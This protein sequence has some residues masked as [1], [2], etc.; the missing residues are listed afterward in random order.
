MLARSYSQVTSI[1]YFVFAKLSPWSL[2]EQIVS[3]LKSRQGRGNLPILDTNVASSSSESDHEDTCDRRTEE[4]F[5]DRKSTNCEDL[6]A[7]CAF[8]DVFT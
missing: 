4:E 2:M 5:M 3:L 6:M 1:P 8:D 7:S